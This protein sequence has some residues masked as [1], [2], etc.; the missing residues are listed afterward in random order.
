MLQG[1]SALG[2]PQDITVEG[3]VREGSTGDGTATFSGTASV[4]MGNGMLPLAGVP[5]TVT[6]S[7]ENLGLTLNAVALPTAAIT[8][9]GI[10]IE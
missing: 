3:E 4:D 9:G 6:A 1:T 5:F 7:A 8:A 2:T 10:S